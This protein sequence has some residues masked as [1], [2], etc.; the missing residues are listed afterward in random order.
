MKRDHDVQQEAEDVIAELDRK[1]GQQAAE[2][3][4]A[5]CF[6]SFIVYVA[7]AVLG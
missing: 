5:A 4:I 6:V 7:L 2:V 3:L 1:R